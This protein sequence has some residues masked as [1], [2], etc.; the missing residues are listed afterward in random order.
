MILMYDGLERYEDYTN[1][2][3]MWIKSTQQLVYKEERAVKI[4]WECLRHELAGRVH[5]F[6]CSLA[7]FGGWV[8]SLW[9]LQAGSEKANFL[10]RDVVLWKIEDLG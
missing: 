6:A 8:L 9:L 7:C 5:W 2:V 10:R 3:K 4:L 1:A